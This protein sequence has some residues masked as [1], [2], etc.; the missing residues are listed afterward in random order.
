MRHNLDVTTFSNVRKLVIF[1]IP[2]R[3]SIS[4]VLCLYIYFN[5]LIIVYILRLT[6]TEVNPAEK[7]EYY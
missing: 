3:F 7:L 5:K 4:S 2:K 1:S 6:V